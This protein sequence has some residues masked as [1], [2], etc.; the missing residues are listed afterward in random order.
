MKKAAIVM[1][2]LLLAGTGV[3]AQ[4]KQDEVN[5]T[6]EKAAEERS[7]SSVTPQRTANELKDDRGQ[8]PETNT[9]DVLN[10]AD[11]ASDSTDTNNLAKASST[12]NETEVITP[13]ENQPQDPEGRKS[14][15]PAVIQRTQSESGSPAILSKENGE[16]KDGTNTVQRSKVNMAGAEVPRNMNL[17][18]KNVGQRN[19][20]TG[21]KIR[22]Q[23]HQ[24]QTEISKA[25]QEANKETVKKQQ[26]GSKEG[27]KESKNSKRK[28]R[29]NK[30]KGGD[31]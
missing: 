16:G 25:E 14:N 4:S 22:T 7:R 6:T 17:S 23:E 24:P 8:V 13:N 15:T 29:R 11:N 1:I 21:Q 31:S 10:G 9:E 19:M 26:N 12:A 28:N 30:D 2:G 18:R 27:E 3:S 5:K 20:N